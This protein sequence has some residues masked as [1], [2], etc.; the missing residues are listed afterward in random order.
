M[1]SPANGITFCTGSLGADPTNDLPTMIREIGH[2]INF[3]HFRNVKYLGEHRFEETAHPS[4]AGSLD[5]AELMQALVD[6]GY[7]GVIRPDHGRAIW[8]EKR[9]GYGLYDRAMG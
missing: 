6:V 4:V 9:Y 7:E 5:M 8:D 1:D 2:R 3:V